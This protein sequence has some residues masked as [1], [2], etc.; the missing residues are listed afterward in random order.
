MGSPSD[1]NGDV[2]CMQTNVNGRNTNLM[3]CT[4]DFGCAYSQMYLE[5]I[6]SGYL[7]ACVGDD[8]CKGHPTNSNER[9]YFDVVNSMSMTCSH[10]SCRDGATICGDE[11]ACIEGVI[12]NPQT[13]FDLSCMG[14]AAYE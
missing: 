3:G 7:L 6:S 13:A 1:C 11:A 4:T 5:Y 14:Y 12:T 2:S 9:A 8:S 10:V